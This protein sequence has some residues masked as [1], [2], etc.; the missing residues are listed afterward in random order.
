MKE[1]VLNMFSICFV[2]ANYMVSI[3][4]KYGVCIGWIY[5]TE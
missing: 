1:Y 4:W 2:Y 3:W 5:G